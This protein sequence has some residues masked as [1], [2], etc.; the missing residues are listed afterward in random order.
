MACARCDFY[1]PKSSTR[2]QLLEA[3]SNL[4]RMFAQIPLTDE[5]RAAVE[6]G[7]AA[8]DRLIERLNDVPTPEGPTPRQLSN[9]NVIP[10]GA[11]DGP[12]APPTRK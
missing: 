10:L 2:A 6:D 4:Q 12:V 3:K 1:L 9:P 11:L 7:A 8:V 5:E